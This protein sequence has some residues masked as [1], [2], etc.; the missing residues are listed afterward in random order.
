MMEQNDRGCIPVVSHEHSTELVGVVTDRDIVMRT[1]AQGRNPLEMT[2]E[3]V[4]SAPVATAKPQESV[5]DC[6]V[7]MEQKQVRRIPV[8]DDSSDCCG[9]VAQADIARRSGLDEAG[10][11]VR[12]VSRP[13][14]RPSQVGR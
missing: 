10:E 4:M 6:C 14:G 7:K 9:I 3:E 2:A 1:I 5:E 13:T 8:V 11:V 12:E